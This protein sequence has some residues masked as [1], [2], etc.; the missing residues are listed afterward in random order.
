M[1]EAKSTAA[2][3]YQ[4]F[5]IVSVL[6]LFSLL[7][8][9]PALA[10]QGDWVNKQY[11]IKGSWEIEQSNGKTLIRFTKNF[12]TKGGPDL[13]VFLSRDNISALNGRIAI[14]N[15]V[16]ISPLKSNRGSQTYTLPA[17]INLEDFKSLIIHCEKYSVLWGGSNI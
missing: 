17:N 7:A 14:N 3:N 8:T 13:K 10:A 15:A 11:K 2:F 6:A 4:A 16:L 9:N 12:S 5:L 1:A